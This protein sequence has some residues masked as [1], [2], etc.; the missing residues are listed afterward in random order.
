MSAS[1]PMKFDKTPIKRD[2]CAVLALLQDFIQKNRTL[3]KL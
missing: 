2:V 1:F 3:N